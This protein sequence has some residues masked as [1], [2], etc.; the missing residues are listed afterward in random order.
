VGNERQSSTPKNI[1]HVVLDDFDGD[2][3]FVVHDIGFVVDDLR[4]FVDPGCGRRHDQVGGAARALRAFAGVLVENAE[5]LPALAGEIDGHEEPPWPR[6]GG[7]QLTA[8]R[9]DEFGRGS[10]WC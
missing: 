7:R 5:P 1:D 2:V 8:G 10:V 3:R 6:G 9:V 4:F